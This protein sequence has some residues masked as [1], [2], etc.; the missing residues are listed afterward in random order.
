MAPLLFGKRALFRGVTP[1]MGVR[2]R[3]TARRSLTP[4]RLDSTPLRRT[5]LAW[6]FRNGCPE[7]PLVDMAPGASNNSLALP[8]AEKG[9]VKSMTLDLYNAVAGRIQPVDIIALWGAAS[10][11]LKPSEDLS[12]VIEH[13]AEFRD[14]VGKE[15]KSPSHI[16]VVR[17]PRIEGRDVLGIESTITHG[18][19]GVQ[20]NPLGAILTGYPKG[21]T[22]AWFQLDAPA[23]ARVDLAAFYECCGQNEGRTHYSIQQLVQFQIGRASCR[24]RV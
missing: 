16:V 15:E 2:R 19:N 8:G 20:N 22:A 3:L 17:Q 14:G 4:P 6:V 1:P 5:L 23:R 11:P 21:S 9:E 24:A 13:I 10:D 12:W 18:R 7:G